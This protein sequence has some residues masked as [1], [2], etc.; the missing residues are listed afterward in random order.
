MFCKTTEES[1]QHLCC[2]EWETTGA[3]GDEWGQIASWVVEKAQG[4][5]KFKYS[6]P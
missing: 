6:N 2:C 1:L 4:R 3:I 5:L